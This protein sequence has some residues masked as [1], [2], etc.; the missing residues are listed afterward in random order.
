MRAAV[1]TGHPVVVE[2]LTTVHQLVTADPES[3][4]L[5]AE[6]SALSVRVPDATVPGGWRPVDPTLRRVA[7]GMLRPAATAVELEFSGGGAGM[8]LARMRNGAHWLELSWPGV[9]PEPLLDGQV[10]TYP[11]A[12]GPGI[13]LVV[14][15]GAVG[16]SH[17]LVVRDAQAATHPGLRRVSLGLAT[18][19]LAATRAAGGATSLVDRDGTEVYVDLYSGPSVDGPWSHRGRYHRMEAP[20]VFASDAPLVVGANSRMWDGTGFTGHVYDLR[21]YDLSS[22]DLVAAPDFTA[23]CPQVS[24]FVDDAGL[25]WQL[26]ATQAGFVPQ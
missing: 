25:T 3:G 17:Y 5:V 18:S 22:G 4:L 12:V 21:I 23:Q 11:D 8:P 19:G 10:A 6:V 2:K 24:T 20:Q 15:A 26:S 7:G 13:D 16:F 14:Q 9:L 1:A